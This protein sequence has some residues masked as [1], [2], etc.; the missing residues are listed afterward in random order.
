MFDDNL[1]VSSTIDNLLHHQKLK[2]KNILK[3]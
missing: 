1:E 3:N 2:V